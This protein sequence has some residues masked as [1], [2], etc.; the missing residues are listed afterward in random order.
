M[1]SRSSLIPWYFIAYYKHSFNIG[2]VNLDILASTETLLN[3]SFPTNDIRLQSFNSP[4]RKDRVGDSHSGV[5]I[6]VKEGFT[7]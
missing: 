3:S 5:I 4:G 2:F 6:Y 1:D 7:L